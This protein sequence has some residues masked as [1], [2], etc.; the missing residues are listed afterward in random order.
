MWLKILKLKNEQDAEWFAKRMALLISGEKGTAHKK[1][2]GSWAIGST[3]DWW[4]HNK[5][6]G[7]YLQYRYPT[8]EK[9]EA[10]QLVLE[11][12]VGV[13]SEQY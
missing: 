6:D 2:H 4:L 10:L 3:N 5:K 9:M 12:I 11:W 1:S 8:K 13:K 7:W